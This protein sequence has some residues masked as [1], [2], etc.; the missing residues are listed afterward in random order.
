MA[1]NMKGFS[2]FGNSPMKQ[3]TD[4]ERSKFATAPGTTEITDA[5]LHKE[6]VIEEGASKGN[7]MDRLTQKYMNLGK[8]SLTKEELEYI[9][10]PK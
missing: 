7:K 1:Y 3:T 10:T 4:K 5:D 9:N 6:Q 8:G 2:G